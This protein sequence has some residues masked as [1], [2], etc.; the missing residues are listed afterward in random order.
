MNYKALQIMDGEWNG[1]ITRQGLVD[2]GAV[3]QSDAQHDRR[4]R[5]EYARGDEIDLY[6]YVLVCRLQPVLYG[7]ALPL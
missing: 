5:D 3:H 2:Q 4:C 1:V 6:P 7:D